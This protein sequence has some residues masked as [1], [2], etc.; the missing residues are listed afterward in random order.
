MDLNS[1]ILIMV[2][3]KCNPFL[4]KLA[5]PLGVG[6]LICEIKRVDKMLRSQSWFINGINCG[7]Q[8]TDPLASYLSYCYTL[9]PRY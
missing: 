2:T 1:Y 3:I 9:T 8:R 6:L 7:S 5:L 4:Y